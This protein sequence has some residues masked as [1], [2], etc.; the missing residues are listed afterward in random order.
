MFRSA[1]RTTGAL[2]L[3]AGAACAAQPVVSYWLSPL[4]GS[5]SDGANWSTNPFYPSNGSGAGAFH[6]VISAIGEPYLVHMNTVAPIDRLTMDSADATLEV[7]GILEILDEGWITAG[8]LHVSTGFIVGTGHLTTHAEMLWTGGGMHG[9]GTTRIAEGGVLRMQGAAAKALTSRTLIN[10]GLTVWTEGEWWVSGA[11]IENNG[12]F[13]ADAALG[14]LTG[15][16]FSLPAGTNFNNHG[17]F[18]KSGAAEARLLAGSTP[19]RFNNHGLVEVDQGVLALLGG[20][21]HSGS[22]AVASGGLL[23]FSGEHTLSSG[24]S[25]AGAGELSIVGGTFNHFG[26]TA[27]SGPLAVSGGVSNFHGSTSLGAATFSGGNATFHQAPKLGA[28]TIAGGDVRVHGGEWTLPAGATLSSGSLGGDADLVVGSTFSWNGGTLAGKGALRVESGAMMTLGGGGSKFLERELINDGELRLGEG[29]LRLAGG[30]VVNN[31]LLRLETLFSQIDFIAIGPVTPGGPGDL[32]NHGTIISRRGLV[33]ILAANFYNYG[34]LDLNNVNQISLF[35]DVYSNF[36]HAGEIMNRSGLVLY[37]SSEFLT[38]AKINGTGVLAISGG[39]HDFTPGV[40]QGTGTLSIGGGVVTLREAPTGFLSLQ[41]GTTIFEY[42]PVMGTTFTTPAHIRFNAGFNAPEGAPLVINSENGL[43]HVHF[44]PSDLAFSTGLIFGGLSGS[45]QISFSGPVE[46]RGGAIEGS[47]TMVLSET[48]PLTLSQSAKTLRR[49]LDAPGEVFWSGG[50][51]TLDGG[52]FISRANLTSA[53]V[54]SMHT[55]AA[56]GTFLNEGSIAVS[57]GSLGLL[58]TTQNNG[59]MHIAPNATL[60]IGGAF[61]QGDGGS[62]TGPGAV[63]FVGGEHLLDKG[64][65][66]NTG[67]VRVMGGVVTVDHMISPSTWSFLGGLTNFQSATTFDTLRIQGGAIGGPGAIE[68]EDM[69]WTRGALQEGGQA[70]IAKDGSLSFSGAASDERTLGRTLVHRGVS[71]LNFG[72]LRLDPGTLINQGQF[73]LSGGV[74]I[75]STNS[76]GLFQNDGTLHVAGLGVI[77]GTDLSFVNTGSV[78]IASNATLRLGALVGAGELGAIAGPGTLEFAGGDV[79]VGGKGPDVGAMRVSG[80]T[81]T[82]EQSPTAPLSFGGGTATFLAPY[83]APSSFTVANSALR[84]QGGFVTPSNATVTVTLG[85]SI[86]LVGNAS[87]VGTLRILD[88]GVRGAGDLT[89][90]NELVWNRGAISG[91]GRLIVTEG[92]TA[93]IFAPTPMTLSREFVNRG[94]ATLTTPSLRFDNGVFRNEGTATV[95]VFSRF[96]GVG[97]GGAFINEG[98]LRMNGSGEFRIADLTGALTFTNLGLLEANDGSVVIRSALAVANHGQY[99]ISQRATL[100]VDGDFINDSDASLAFAVG[101]KKD[102]GLAGLMTITGDASLGGSLIVTTPDALGRVWG[103]RWTVLSFGSLSAEFDAIE[104]PESPD[105][106]LRWYARRDADSYSVGVSHIAD[107]DHDG[108][109]GFADLNVIASNFN[110][111]GSWAQGDVD[112]DGFVGFAD[113]NIVL[114]LFNVA[115]PRNVPAPGA[116]ASL[117]GGLAL[118]GARRRR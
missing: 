49:T 72:A 111:S 103:E 39:V 86:D 102:R 78:N 52:D 117:L 70:V 62:I 34:V 43:G 38:G 97:Q 98:V 16:G 10:D 93:A 96:D 29:R 80:G 14:M 66:A 106:M 9:G 31:G 64:F 28:M 95:P 115:A 94:E 33:D 108:L 88:G 75:R 24:A 27:L 83:V 69:V 118:A 81:V 35:T 25:I 105:E 41:G 46:W 21:D 54:V 17:V 20:G 71:A 84:F 45:G 89:V 4:S 63:E 109:I 100:T 65:I 30:D 7:A 18:T 55:S 12:H 104:L 32:I 76:G 15:L 112:G 37:G 91:E 8:T 60:R 92:A 113:L 56:G 114:S 19:F 74:A 48:S 116:V 73:T 101:G 82:F 22:F 2:A 13:I 40:Y 87:T 99:A 67:P 47:G 1:R 36:I 5:W 90:S 44:G 57:S 58:A 50:D 59:A 51:L 53:G 26:S 42:V 107:I 85:A 68:M 23:R 6:A 11:S 77:E 79:V 110:A 3:C 61:T